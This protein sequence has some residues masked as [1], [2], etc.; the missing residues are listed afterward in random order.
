MSAVFDGY[1]SPE[2]TDPYVDVCVQPKICDHAD[3]VTRRRM[4]QRPHAQGCPFKDQPQQSPEVPM[5][6]PPCLG[7]KWEQVRES[8]RVRC[9]PHGAGGE[10]PLAA[11]SRWMDPSS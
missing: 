3:S 4:L 5:Y 11:S 9:A 7:L 2:S 1:D 6:R 8:H 10:V